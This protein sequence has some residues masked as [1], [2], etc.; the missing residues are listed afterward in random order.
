[1]AGE[2]ETLEAKVK[3]LAQRM[4]ELSLKIDFLYSRLEIPIQQPKT[5][6][7]ELSHSGRSVQEGIIPWVDKASLLP[8]VS[9]VCFL[10]VVALILRT[11]TDSN[12]L[13]RPLG[14]ILGMGYAGLLMVVGYWRYGKRAALA[15]VFSVCGALLISSVLL[16]SYQRFHSLP[17]FSVYSV[18]LATGLGAFLTGWRF[19]KGLPAAVGLMS[20]CTTAALIDFPDPL[21]PALAGI[22]FIASI[23]SY[24]L[25][26]LQGFSWIS[27]VVLLMS[28]LALSYWSGRLVIALGRKDQELLQLL[29]LSWFLPSVGSFSIM[30]PIL[31]LLGTVGAKPQDALRFEALVPGLTGLWNFVCAYQVVDS[32]GLNGQLLG[33]AGFSLG[34][35]HLLAA[36]WLGRKASPGARGTNSFAIAACILMGLSLLQLPGDGFLSVVFLSGIALGLFGLSLLWKSGGVRLSSYLLQLYAGTATGLFLW[37]K[38]QEGHLFSLAFQGAIVSSLSILHYRWCVR[39]APPYE[40]SAFFS[41]YDRQHRSSVLPLAASVLSGFFVLRA[42]IQ[43]AV[44]L[45]PGDFQNSF[46]CAQSVLLNFTAAGLML[47]AY[48]RA[49]QGARNLAILLTLVGAV[50]VFMFDLLQAR[51]VPLMLSVLSFGLAALLESILLGRWQKSPKALDRRCFSQA[52]DSN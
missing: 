31:C 34:A 28:L 13:D 50:K 40:S 43:E 22:L 47:F 27:W 23:L 29:A 35:P 24:M 12:V 5:A 25:R 45:F 10:L 32:W 33:L 46:L 30:L 17:R 19:K 51:G 7:E 26:R 41:R 20:M 49:D 48:L 11:L 42:M 14:S 15:G 9:I 4:D 38:P 2:D 21:F 44:H 36:H 1:M 8:G 39:Q 37:G 16:E 52:Q 3:K 18:L 6:H